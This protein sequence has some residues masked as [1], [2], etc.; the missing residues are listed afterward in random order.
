[1]FEFDKVQLNILARRDMA[2][3]GGELVGEVGHLPQ[4]IRRQPSERDLNAHHLDPGLPLAVNSIL[5]PEGLEDVVREITRKDT[6]G[7]RFEGLDFF[8]Y[9]GRDGL[10]FNRWTKIHNVWSHDHDLAGSETIILWII[11]TPSNVIHQGM[12][13]L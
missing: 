4:L 6:L 8:G 10:C 9:M 12:L 5:Q 13:C 11:R 3:A 2:H 1:M 7:F